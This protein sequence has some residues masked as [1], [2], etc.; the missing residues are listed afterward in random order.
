[1]RTAMSERNIELPS[2]LDEDG[3]DRLPQMDMLMRIDMTGV[4]AHQATEHL[5]LPRDFIADDAPILQ[6]DHGVHGHPLPGAKDLF[7]QVDMQSKPEA[8]MFPRVGCRFRR[9]APAA[10]NARAGHD[11]VVMCM[12]DTA[13]HTVALAEIVGIDDHILSGN[14]R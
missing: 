10:R 7:P 1:M 5:Q 4:T 3:A 2:H 11:D 9:G 8:L 6:G 13:I 14:R 12:D